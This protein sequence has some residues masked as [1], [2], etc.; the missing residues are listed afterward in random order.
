MLMSLKF[1]DIVDLAYYDYSSFFQNTSGDS[2]SSISFVY[3]VYRFI[4]YQINF[5]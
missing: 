3:D 5:Y 1:T 4:T 2:L